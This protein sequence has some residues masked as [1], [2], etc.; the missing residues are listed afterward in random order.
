M[1]FS[2]SVQQPASTEFLSSCLILVSFISLLWPRVRSRSLCSHYR[3]SHNYN[4]TFCSIK[5]WSV[6]EMGLDGTRGS[7]RSGRDHNYYLYQTKLPAWLPSARHSHSLSREV[8][9]RREAED[10]NG[11]DDPPPLPRLIIHSGQPS[12]ASLNMG[13]VNSAWCE[14]LPNISNLGWYESG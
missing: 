12:P 2:S 4:Q 13:T 9:Q 14:V 10:D 8:R 6:H 5:I 1:T 3:G 11:P 7:V